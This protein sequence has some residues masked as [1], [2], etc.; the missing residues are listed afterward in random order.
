MELEQKTHQSNLTFWA[1]R[2]PRYTGKNR[3]FRP[4]QNQVGTGY[5]YRSPLAEQVEPLLANPERLFEAEQCQLL[6]DSRSAAV[7]V[8]PVSLPTGKSAVV[9]KWLK[10]KG[11]GYRLKSLFRPS[12][13]YRSWVY[14][15]SLI[16]RGLP[17]ARPLVWLRR[18]R[19]WLPYDD[20]L[21]F[22]LVPD[23]L[24]LPEAVAERSRLA[25]PLRNRVYQGWAERLGR[26][27]ERLHHCG[28]SHRDLKAANILLTNSNEPLQA[29]PVLIDLVGVSTGQGVSLEVRQ[30]DVARLAASFVNLPA[31]R[32]SHRLRFLLSYLSPRGEQRNW[33]AWW[34]QL[35]AQVGEKVRRNAERGRPLA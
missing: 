14:G 18:R 31:V 4:F 23:A 7:A 19:L 20:F 8:V 32:H 13:A 28:V 11:W 9:L 5:A 30:R 16:D 12:P 15:Q 10:P 2:F 17:T 29:G 26:L 22:E 25:E 34:K 3:E 27:I 35:E 6:K 33:K 1:R 21:A 24:G